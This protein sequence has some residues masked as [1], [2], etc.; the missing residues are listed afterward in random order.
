M[1]PDAEETCDDGIDSDC[2]GVGFEGDELDEPQCWPV[3]CECRSGKGSSDNGS[4]TIWLVALIA[5]AHLRRRERTSP[6]AASGGTSYRVLGVTI[7]LYTLLVASPS[8]VSAAEGESDD[9]NDS[10]TALQEMLNSGRCEEAQEVLKDKVEA[11]PGSAV[12]WRLL[13]DAER[14]L[15][16]SREAI[17]AYN[18]TLSLSGKD[19]AIEVLLK[20][21]RANVSI[22][23]VRLEDSDESGSQS[24][25]DKVFVYLLD[26]DER[27]EPSWSNGLEARFQDLPA[28]KA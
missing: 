6:R 27:L 23:D 17:F 8:P 10:A 16:R 25:Q 15:G 18:R 3:G 5:L 14:C 19:P 11:S 13:A 9:D 21:L 4:P 12:F 7:A 22:L 24:P 1:N 26:G 20:S 28:S 2:N